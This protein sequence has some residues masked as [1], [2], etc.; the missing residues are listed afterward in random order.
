[1]FH[2]QFEQGEAGMNCGILLRGVAK[3]DVE[4]GQVLCK[5]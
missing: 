2:K 1:M 3:D 5:P 4:R